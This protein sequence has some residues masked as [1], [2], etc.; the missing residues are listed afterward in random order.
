MEN[1]KVLSLF[2]GIGAPEKALTNI[3]INYDLVGFSEIEQNAIKSYSLIHGIDENLNLGDIKEINID[4]LVDFDL[5][6]AGFPCTDISH[7]GKQQGFNDKTTSSGLVNYAIEI[8]S[9]KKP[10]FIVF[11]NVKNLISKRFK[12]DFEVMV[13]RVES[14]GYTCHYKLLNTKDFGLPQNRER[15]Y[16]IFIRND[17]HISFDFNFPKKDLISLYDILDKDDCIDNINE[18]TKEK[19]L[20]QFSSLEIINDELINSNNL[21]E[22]KVKCLNS[23]NKEGKQP[24]QQYRVYSKKGI[25]T[26]LSSQLNGRYN[27]ISKLG[28][29]RKLTP[30]EAYLL[31]GFSEDD[32]NKVKHLSS[33]SL[34]MQAGNSI[35]VPV[36]EEIFKRLFA[37]LSVWKSNNDIIQENENTYVVSN[38]KSKDNGQLFFDLV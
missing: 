4:K 12:E 15:V 8:I 14:K 21:V 9:I 5:L 32:Y 26:T 3:G 36:L 35:S 34:F 27:V 10:K 16:M 38:L 2:S 29:I 30:R 6:L 1:I 11:E 18:S 24:S 31:Q 33:N 23:K 28:H 7:N 37:D 22:G 25:M 20:S 17:Q 19:I 13:S